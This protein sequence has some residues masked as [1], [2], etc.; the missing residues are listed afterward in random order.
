VPIGSRD[1]EEAKMQRRFTTLD[2]FTARRF[3]GNPL[4]VV[5]DAEALDSQAMQ[6]I[7]REFN[8]PET[9]FVLPARD[10]SNAAQLRIFTPAAELPFAG[11]PTVGTAVLFGIEGEGA[12]RELTFEEGIGSVHCRVELRSADRGFARFDLPRLPDRTGEA[13]DAVL[14]ADALGLTLD[15]LG[16]DDFEPGKWSAGLE[17]A[18]I[19]L[20]GLDAIGR[21][22]CDLAHWPAAF[23][24]S[25]PRTAYLYCR[26]TAESG[27]ALHARMFAPHM[28]IPEDPATGSAAA[29]L[30]GVIARYAGLPDGEHAI[31][32]E[33]GYE[34][35]R[36][37]VI[38]LALTLSHGALT[39]AS[40]GGE[41]IIVSRGE[42][43][44]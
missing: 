14:L 17:F 33:Q 9:V 40:I 16:C 19:P 31:A 21:A 34:M 23:G 44:T 35:G 28:G 32:I 10:R 24:A 13:A 18:M 7:A 4:A 41:A 39:A 38:E 22:R 12:S 36:P 25:G 8:L 29:A 3:A 15:D 26:E 43:E 1:R 37:S 20:R 6:T 30:A 2:V 5:R 11:H 42:I 27:H